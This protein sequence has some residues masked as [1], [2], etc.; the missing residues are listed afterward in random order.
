M[1]NQYQG[2]QD[3]QVQQM[4]PQQ[5]EVIMKFYKSGF[6]SFRSAVGKFESDANHMKKSGFKVKHFSPMPRNFWLQNIVAVSYER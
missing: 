2:L 6:F 5:N 4:Q 1:Q 3:Q